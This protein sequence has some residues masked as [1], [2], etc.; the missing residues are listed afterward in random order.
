[1]SGPTTTIVCHGE[2][3]WSVNWPLV[4]MIVRSS[5]HDLT[6]LQAAAFSTSDTSSWNP[7][8]LGMPETTSYEVDW[9]RHRELKER[10]A[11]RHLDEV[12]LLVRTDIRAAVMQLRE[13]INRSA[14][15]KQRFRDNLQ[16]ASRRTQ[17]AIEDAVGNYETA[18][19]VARVTRDVAGSV[20]V[21]GAG[22]L[23]GG[24]AVAAVAGGSAFQGVGTY[25]DTGDVGAALI[26]GTGSII[27]NL[28]P[29][30]GAAGQTLKARAGHEAMIA[31]VGFQ[32]DLASGL[33]ASD[34]RTGDHGQ[35]LGD[36][37][38]DA[39]AKAALS[40]ASF[41]GSEAV[42]SVV[43]RVMSRTGV[44]VHLR[45]SRSSPAQAVSAAETGALAGTVFAVSF[46]A[47]VR[48]ADL[49]EGQQ[50]FERDTLPAAAPAA[51]CV[52]ADS[53]CARHDI[54]DDAIKPVGCWAGQ[55]GMGPAAW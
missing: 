55:G 23:S 1:M 2:T 27:V 43:T 47:G 25:Q 53:A 41:A 35:P 22:L 31:L 5:A 15:A 20:F 49:F 36:A 34:Q 37:L 10:A 18:T 46:K 39:A 45:I 33:V 29:L 4:R 11:A 7:F 9:A 40:A 14:R 51:R 8:S 16:E 28:I 52:G 6:L 32:F 42:R 48:A 38:G 19:S 13:L 24:A 3:Q 44:P 21:A 30:G 12:T 26:S 17:A 50:A 54:L